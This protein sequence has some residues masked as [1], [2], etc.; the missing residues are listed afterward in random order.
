MAIEGYR[1]RT[2]YPEARE[3]QKPVYFSRSGYSLKGV[4]ISPPKIGIKKQHY[5]DWAADEVVVKL[6]HENGANISRAETVEKEQR[7]TEQRVAGT[8]EW[9]DL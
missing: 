9:F 1:D 2:G 6:L 8:R 7:C 4:P 5:T 3:I